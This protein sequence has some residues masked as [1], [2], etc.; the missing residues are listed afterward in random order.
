[1]RNFTNTPLEDSNCLSSSSPWLIFLDLA[2]SPATYYVRNNADVSWNSINYTASGFTI[3][4]IPAKSTKEL[5]EITIDVL[6][7]ATLVKEL[8]SNYGFIGTGVTVYYMHYASIGTITQAN[9]PLRFSFK[10][11]GCDIKSNVVSF[12]LGVPAYIRQKFPARKFRKDS[13]DFLYKGDYCWMKGRT[14]SSETDACNQSF[15]NCL[16]HWE[17][18]GKPFDYV[19]F[20]GAPTIGKGSYLY[21]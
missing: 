8:E 5:P 6:I 12:T 20:G 13:C 21:G 10:V 1:M 4:A 17:D 15:A 11:I 2:T 16:A 9:W 3:S 7:V 19:P 18:Q 14:V